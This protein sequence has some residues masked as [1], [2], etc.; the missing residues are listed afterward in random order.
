DIT[1]NRYFEQQ[2]NVYFNT[3]L[4]KGRDSGHSHRRRDLQNRFLFPVKY[5]KQPCKSPRSKQRCIQR[6][7]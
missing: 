2:L 1:T 6:L 7:S 4:G 3:D 5:D